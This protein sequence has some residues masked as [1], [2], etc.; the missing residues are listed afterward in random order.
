MPPLTDILRLG[1]FR[2]IS[3]LCF[4]ANWLLINCHF[5]EIRNNFFLMNKNC[6]LSFL[7][8]SVKKREE[9][10]EME[11]EPKIIL[12]SF[13]AQT[14]ARWISSLSVSVPSKRIGPAT[15]PHL[16][17]LRPRF[18]RFYTCRFNF[19]NWADFM[20]FLNF[21]SSFLFR[22]YLQITDPSIHISNNF[23]SSL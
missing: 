21:T 6:L 23:T 2:A 5:F 8:A 13:L 11:I 20:P 1:N 18:W 16:I 4:K 7:V 17:P 10:S 3:R 14:A 19:I 9:M 12:I 22:F 15:S